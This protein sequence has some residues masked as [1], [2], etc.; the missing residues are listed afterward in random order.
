MVYKTKLLLLIGWFFMSQSSRWLWV[1]STGTFRPWRHRRVHRAKMVSLR[2]GHQRA[3]C[4]AGC[5]WCDCAW[6]TGE[7]GPH[8]TGD[9]PALVQNRGIPPSGDIQLLGRPLHT[10]CIR[11]GTDGICRA[12]EIP[13]LGQP[14]VN[15]EA[16]LPRAWKILGRVWRPSLPRRPTVQPSRVW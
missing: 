14:R 2:G 16:V 13:R 8:P 7:A 11:D 1:R 10:V 3:V 5:C 9:R 15:G 4:H 12:Q 6:D